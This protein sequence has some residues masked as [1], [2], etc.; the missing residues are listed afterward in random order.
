MSNARVIFCLF[1]NYWKVC[2]KKGTELSGLQVTIETFFIF[3][4]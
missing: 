2:A 1:F 3:K 4:L